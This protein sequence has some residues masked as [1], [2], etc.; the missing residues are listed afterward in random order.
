MDFILFAL[1]LSFHYKPFWFLYFPLPGLKIERCRHCPKLFQTPAM[2]CVIL[3]LN[4]A[5]NRYVPFSKF[6]GGLDLQGGTILSF[7]CR[8]TL[9][10]FVF[11]LLSQFLCL[12]VYLRPDTYSHVDPET[13][14][15]DLFGLYG[16]NGIVGTRLVTVDTF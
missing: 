2:Q 6:L 11:S 15:F 14:D 3:K 12:R 13:A 10:I 1:P 8:N 4:L 7:S 16:R 9:T 5:W